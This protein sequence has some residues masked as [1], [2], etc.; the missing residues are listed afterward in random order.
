MGDN[1]TKKL[2]MLMLI[3]FSFLLA[4]RDYYDGIDPANPNFITA[5]S[6]KLIQRTDNSYTGFKSWAQDNEAA[7]DGNVYCVYSN[8]NVT[9]TFNREHTWCSSWMPTNPPDGS[10]FEYADYHNLLPTQV[11]ANSARGN[12]PFGIVVSGIDYELGG[13][14]RGKDASNKTVFEPRD[15]HK[16]DAAR[17][18][19]YMAVCYNG[20]QSSN[21]SIGSLTAGQSTDVLIA[22]HLQDP[23]SDWERAINDKVFAKQG[24]RNP[25]VD[26]PSWANYINFTN[27]TYV[28]Q[29]A[30]IEPTNYPTNFAAGTVTDNSIQIN[31]T[32]AVAG[33]QA[34]SG[35]LIQLKNINSFTLPSDGF[36]ITDDNDLSDGSVSKNISYSDLDTYT[37]TGLASGTYYYAKI[38]SYNGTSGSINYKTDG[39]VPSITQQTTGISNPSSFSALP[40]SNT[41]INVY[42]QK[43]PLLDGVILA[44]NTTDTFGTPQNGTAY[45]VDQDIA[46]GGKVIYTGTANNYFPHTGLTEAT[47]YYYKIWSVNASNTYSAGLTASATTTGGSVPTDILSENFD[48][49]TPTGGS[50]DVSPT[51]DNYTQTPGWTGTKIYTNGGEAKMGSGSGQGSIITP[52]VNLSNNGG[53]ATLSFDLRQ[54]NSTDNPLVQVFHAPN[55]TTFTQVGTDITAPATLETKTIPITGGT[56]SSK[57]KIIAKTTTYNRF[58]L[59]NFNLKLNTSIFADNTNLQKSSHLTSN[60]PNP[61][62]PSTSIK[63]FVNN[64]QDIR[65]NVYNVRGSKVFTQIKS[66]TVGQNSIKWDAGDLPA[67]IYLYSIEADGKIL[68]GKMS[69]IK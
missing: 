58:Y 62:N 16:G 45:A 4:Q 33:E 61:F 12:L 65:L 44:Y 54:Y 25:F 40:I 28:P 41:Q 43:N 18:L 14:K 68:N 31:W 38:Y 67:G 15:P 39:T 48:G 49:F 19:L 36:P 1:M 32:D 66:C 30:T 5:L 13:S 63:F 8:L 42:W 9:T 51:L 27:L 2:I 53:N 59:D 11:E 10:S 24:N 21:W 56:A 50:T 29:V 35:Y 57:I 3:I 20:Y 60:Y 34:P 7:A 23:P 22:W 69:L 37:F 26:N 52:T 47:T 64:N 55:G 17:I 46:G 6:A